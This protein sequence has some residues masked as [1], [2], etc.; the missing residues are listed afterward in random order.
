M[1]V[2]VAC[3]VQMLQIAQEVSDTLLLPAGNLHPTSAEY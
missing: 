1:L 2:T 3:K